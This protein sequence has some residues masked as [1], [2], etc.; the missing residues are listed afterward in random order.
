M[1]I[2]CSPTLQH[3]KAAYIKKPITDHIVVLPCN[4]VMDQLST[5]Q[6]V[7]RCE[8]SILPHGPQH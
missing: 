4:Q 8:M 6:H 7:H 5:D 2:W 1:M 3:I